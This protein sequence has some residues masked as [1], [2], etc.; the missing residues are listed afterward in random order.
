[1]ELTK[2]VPKRA[3]RPTLVATG[4]VDVLRELVDALLTGEEEELRVPVLE[5]V[6]SRESLESTALGHG[7]ALPHARVRGL[8]DLVCAIGV[9]KKGIDFRAVDQAKVHIVVLMLYPPSKQSVYLNFVAGVVRALHR[10]ERAKAVRDAGDAAGILSVFEEA[11]HETHHAERAAVGEKAG[12][13]KLE[14]DGIAGTELFLLARLELYRDMMDGSARGK[15]E[16]ERRVADIRSL[17]SKRVLAHYDRLCRRGGAAL[18][19]VEG[20]ICQGCLVKLPSQ[21][22]QKIRKETDTVATCGHCNRFLYP[23]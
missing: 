11:A 18:V 3:I 21:L 9:S 7:I 12:V 5:Q 14:A 16:I 23:L 15:A 8:D 2:H 1:M 6:V 4:K 22:A 20:G 17:V 13:E 10:P 19:T